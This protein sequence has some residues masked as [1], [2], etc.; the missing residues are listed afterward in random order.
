MHPVL[1]MH[2][3]DQFEAVFRQ[4]VHD[5]FTDDMALVVAANELLGAPGTEAGEA[6]H[7][8]VRQQF[9]RVR[10][11]QKQFRHVVGLVKQDGCLTPGVLFVAPVAEFGGHRRRAG[12]IAIVRGGGVVAEVFD[13]VGRLV[14]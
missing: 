12:P 13:E 3:T 4:V 10:P 2:A 14:D 9:L 7:A 11:L 1:Q 5:R 8:Q 6:V